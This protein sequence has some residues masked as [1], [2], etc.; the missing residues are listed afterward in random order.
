MPFLQGER[1]DKNSSVLQFGRKKG[2]Y[3]LKAA[4]R[5]V[6]IGFDGLEL[7]AFGSWRMGRRQGIR[8]LRPV[9]AS[10]TDRGYR[11]I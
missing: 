5:L 11:A 2:N 7:V 8:N 9:G 1:K 4:V 10:R 6:P 3:S